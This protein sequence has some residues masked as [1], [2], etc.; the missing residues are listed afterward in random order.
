MRLTGVIL[1]IITMN[2]SSGR[3][4]GHVPESFKIVMALIVFSVI[5]EHDSFVKLQLSLVSSSSSQS[6]SAAENRYERRKE[7]K[8]FFMISL[9]GFSERVLGTYGAG[10]EEKKVTSV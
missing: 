2:K 3:L 7:L 9:E 4:L 6:S 1:G 5:E 10:D 8:E